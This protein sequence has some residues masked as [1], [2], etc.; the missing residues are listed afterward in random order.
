MN[1]T[2]TVSHLK[3]VLIPSLDNARETVTFRKT[4]NIDLIACGEGINGDHLTYGIRAY[5]IEPEFFQNLKGRNAYFLELTRVGFVHSLLVYVSEA[6]FNRFVAVI[7]DCLDLNNGARTCFDDCDRDYF[8]VCGK[9]LSHT[10]FLS[11]DCFIHR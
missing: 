5:V 6:D 7:A 8:S 11:N 4:Y 3:S 9:D 10:Q 2:Y 1:G